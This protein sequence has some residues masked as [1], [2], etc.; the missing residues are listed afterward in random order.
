ME[1]IKSYDFSSRP[2]VVKNVFIF[3]LKHCTKKNYHGVFRAPTSKRK[4]RFQLGTYQ[5]LKKQWV[6]SQLEE[7]L[8]TDTKLKDLTTEV[9]QQK[10]ELQ[11]LA[12]KM[13]STSELISRKKRKVC[14]VDIFNEKHLSYLIACTCLVF[15][16]C[17]CL[18]LI[19][20]KLMFVSI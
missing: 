4:Q 11:I 20:C 15:L 2:F 18:I 9:D 5:R 7:K 14:I 1:N 12:K 17:L 3:A 10:A 8:D 6:L 13:H 19:Q 16:Y